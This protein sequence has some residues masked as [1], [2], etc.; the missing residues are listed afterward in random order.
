MSDHQKESGENVLAQHL[1]TKR[2]IGCIAEACAKI[3]Y[4]TLSAKLD[5]FNRFL[6]HLSLDTAVFREHILQFQQAVTP[7]LWS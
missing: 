1:A 3:D 4:S 7:T 2:Q 5:T 6:K